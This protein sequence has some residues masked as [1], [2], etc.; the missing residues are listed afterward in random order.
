MVYL[1]D[2]NVLKDETMNIMIAGRKCT[3]HISTRTLTHDW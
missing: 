2:P 3:F 1:L